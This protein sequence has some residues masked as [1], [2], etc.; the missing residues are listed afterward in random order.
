MKITSEKNAGLS[1]PT[2][3]MATDATERSDVQSRTRFSRNTLGYYAPLM[4]NSNVD[5]NLYV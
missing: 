3:G 5:K 4:N 2:C 1:V